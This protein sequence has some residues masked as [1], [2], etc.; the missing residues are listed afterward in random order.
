MTHGGLSFFVPNVSIGLDEVEVHVVGVVPSI[1]HQSHC[2]THHHY[3]P[4]MHTAVTAMQRL[5]LL[6]WLHSM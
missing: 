1:V 4:Y 5:V 3:L 2:R 6:I